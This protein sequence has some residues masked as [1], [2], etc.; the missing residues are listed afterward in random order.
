M[1]KGVRDRD[2]RP[3]IQSKWKAIAKPT[4][5]ERGAAHDGSLGVSEAQ[6]AWSSANFSHVSHSGVESCWN[7]GSEVGVIFLY[8]VFSDP[9][10]GGYLLNEAGSTIFPYHHHHQRRRNRSDLPETILLINTHP[11]NSAFLL[12][13][14]PELTTMFCLALVDLCRVYQCWV[15]HT[16]LS[17]KSQL[18]ELVL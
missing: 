13:S 9:S 1:G 17:L 4:I 7:L 12:T 14:A 5:L 15:S 10:G 6:Q 16:G 3:F 2:I 11:R 18:N 8:E